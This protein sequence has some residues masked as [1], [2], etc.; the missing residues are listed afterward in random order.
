MQVCCV[1]GRGG[2]T[3][4]DPLMAAHLAP[5]IICSWEAVARGMEAPPACPSRQVAEKAGAA[6]PLPKC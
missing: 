6:L 5:R 2:V 3:N 4:R 1:H